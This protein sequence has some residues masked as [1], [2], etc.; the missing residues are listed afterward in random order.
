MTLY[1]LG[2]LEDKAEIVD[3]IEVYDGRFQGEA[4]IPWLCV[5]KDAKE[6]FEN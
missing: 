1:A 4:R 6:L 2:I 5:L 3:F